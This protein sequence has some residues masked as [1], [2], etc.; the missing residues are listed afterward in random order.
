MEGVGNMAINVAAAYLDNKIKTATPAELTL[1]L[2]DGS[3]KFCNIAIMAIEEN[4]NSKANTNII[5]A[6]KI[7]LELRSSL[8]HKYEISKNLDLLYEYIYSELIEA[9][10]KKDKNVLDE[11]L[12]SLR[13]LR[14]TWKEAM[15]I[16]TNQQRIAE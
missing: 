5:K 11:V 4:D 10:M 13:E 1:M 6:Q 9:N 7:M 16:E 2:Y 14:D 12:E 15:I 3:I 8:D